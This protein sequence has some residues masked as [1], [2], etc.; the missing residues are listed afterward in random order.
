MPGGICTELITADAAST[1][2]HQ[3][4]Q[5]KTYYLRNTANTFFS[6]YSATN[7]HLIVGYHFPMF[8]T[9]IL[10]HIKLHAAIKHARESAYTYQPTVSYPTSYDK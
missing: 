2:Q 9:C 3:T 5:I 8:F 6:I 4:T 7:N 1:A 10:L